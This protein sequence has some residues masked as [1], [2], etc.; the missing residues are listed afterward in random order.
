MLA[1]TAR[2]L[3]SWEE[4]GLDLTACVNLASSLLAD[5]SI[6]ER[7]AS[8]VDEAGL[9]CSRFTFEITE[10]DLGNRDAPHLK[11][12]DA[13]REKGFRVCLDDFRVAATSL[14]AF[15]SLPFDEIKIQATSLRRAQGNP[16]KLQVLAAVA[17]LAKSLG[18]AVCVAG[19][20]DLETVEYLKMLECDKMQGFLISEA[21]MP[22]II[23]RVYSA[24][25]ED[26]A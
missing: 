3:K 15:E 10:H 2:Q 16:V 6:A 20:E 24:S 11:T 23:R 12:L 9:E 5:Q 17:G 14:G 21:V 13:L 26:V 22:N 19:I 1:E 18:V 8:I 4:R 25:V 7:Y